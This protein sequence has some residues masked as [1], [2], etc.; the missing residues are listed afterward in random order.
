MNVTLVR[1]LPVHDTLLKCL[2]L[3]SDILSIR[4]HVQLNSADAFTTYQYHYEAGNFEQS[5]ASFSHEVDLCLSARRILLTKYD[6]C[7]FCGAAV[8]QNM[9]V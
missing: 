1:P 5:Q 9:I 4:C 2:P 6:D 7:L 3:K 8:V